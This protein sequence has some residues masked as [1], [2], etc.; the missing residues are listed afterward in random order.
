MKIALCNE[1]LRDHP[2]ERQCALAAELGYEGLEIAPFTLGDEPH[3]LSSHRVGELRQAAKDAG[4]A[5]TGLHW[6]LVA[7]KGLSIT[8]ADAK[9]RAFT[10][11]TVHRLV[12]LCAELG[13]S[14]VVHGS[15]AQRMFGQ[16]REDEDRANALHYFAG[17]AAVAEAAGI[18][19]CLEPLAPKQ[20]NFLTSVAEADA[21]V[22]E[23]GSSSMHTMIDCCAAGASESEP[24]P[25]LIARWMPQ[26]AIAHVHFNDPN[27][28]GP[29]E[30]DMDFAPV[31]AA[32]EDAGYTGWVGVEPFVYKPDGLACTARA[33]GHV[34]G[35]EAALAIHRNDR[36]ER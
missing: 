11:E 33:I 17:I 27:R 26:G 18:T 32:L 10:L 2:F 30:G 24:V 16:G 36:K 1:V 19:Y 35:I 22:E 25:A 28:R 21:V 7:P 13:G 12:N 23:I 5:I 9:T 15:P 31:V 8:S 4:I 6:L 29:G 20:T 34:R 3:R 14:Y